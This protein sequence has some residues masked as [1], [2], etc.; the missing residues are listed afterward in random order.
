MT[1][2]TTDIEPTS[3]PNA[4]R[5]PFGVLMNLIITLLA[6]TFLGVTGGNIAYARAA[7]LETVNAYRARNQADLIAIAQI[8]AFGLAALGSLSLSMADDI[9]IPMIL[10]LRGN[11][12]ACDRSAERN[13]R[14]LIKSQVTERLPHDPAPDPEPFDDN[15]FLS[16]AAAQEL[17]AESEARLREPEPKADPAPA[18]EPARAEKRHREMWAIAMVKDASEITASLPNLPPAERDAAVIRAAAMTSAAHDLLYGAASPGGL[19]GINRPN[20]NRE[21]RPL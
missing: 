13:R 18:A 9:S 19:P 8:I 17:A 4:A 20:A 2:I 7:A 16:A 21:P 3:K 1:N 5:H 12:I 14:A 15:A 10:R 6:P 11:A